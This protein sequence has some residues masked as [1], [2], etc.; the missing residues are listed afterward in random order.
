MLLFITI[1]IYI[2]GDACQLWPIQ[3]IV[4]NKVFPVLR[5][6]SFQTKSTHITKSFA[7]YSTF[8]KVFKN[9]TYFLL[10]YCPTLCN[11]ID[12]GSSVHGIFQARMLEWVTMSSSREPSWFRDRTQVSCIAGRFFTIWVT[13]ETH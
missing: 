10:A 11:P 2:Y 7:E 9:T 4:V 3:W 5:H 12:Y 13:R 8:T 6:A 1:Y